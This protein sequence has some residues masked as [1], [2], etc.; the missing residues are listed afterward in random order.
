[1]LRALSHPGLYRCATAAAHGARVFVASVLLAQA[2]VHMHEPAYSLTA[3]PLA[4]GVLLAPAVIAPS[5]ER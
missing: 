4:L 2:L 1:M 5:R 3:L